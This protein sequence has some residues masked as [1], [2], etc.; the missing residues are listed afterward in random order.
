MLRRS[1]P[2][3]LNQ[4]PQTTHQQSF[5]IGQI[6]DPH[7]DEQ[8]VGRHRGVDARQA[9]LEKRGRQRYGQERR[10]AQRI[11]GVPVVERVRQQWQAKNQLRE[12]EH[13]RRP[14]E[15]L[16]V[17]SGGLPHLL[18]HCPCNSM[19]LTLYRS[20]RLHL[21]KISPFVSTALRSGNSSVS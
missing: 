5:R 12:D 2:Q 13:D 11:N 3:G 15:E 6:E 21:A 7:Q 4:P 17:F 8:K 18:P 14:P 16:P 19:S 20:F 10:E 9:N 1:I